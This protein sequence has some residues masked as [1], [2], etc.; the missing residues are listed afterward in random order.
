MS[1]N[2]LGE[3]SAMLRRALD[4]DG[5]DP[6][7]WRIH[8]T[9][10]DLIA[11]TGA[12]PVEAMT[13][14]LIAAIDAPLDEA[15]E[16]VRVALEM[17]T[18]ADRSWMSR[19]D[20]SVVDALVDRAR[21]TGAPPSMVSLAAVLSM[22]HGSLDTV[23]SV[24]S[25]STEAEVRAD[26]AIEAA[27]S[28]AR[29]LDLIDGGRFGE[30]VAYLDTRAGTV[31][32]PAAAAARALALY[33]QGDLHKALEVAAAAPETFETASAQAIVW[34]RRA[35]EGD[36]FDEDV[37]PVAQAS[38][39]ASAAARLEPS[40]ADGLL[41]RAQVE[42]EGL[43][44]VEAGR[45]LLE[46]AVRRLNGE[47]ERVRLWRLQQATRDDDL[48]RYMKVEVAAACNRPGELAAIQP[49]DLP[50]GR[51]AWRQDA[52]VAHLVAVAKENDRDPDGA[53]QMY[54]TA[55]GYY[56]NAGEPDLALDVLRSAT[57]LRPSADDVIQLADDL[58]MASYR[59][60]QQ[61]PEA[62][63]RTI[64]QGLETVDRLGQEGVDVT[65]S[66]QIEGAYR[67]GLLLARVPNLAAV[68]LVDVWRPLPWLLAVALDDPSH[69][70][71]AAHLAWALDRAELAR[72][73]L[74]YAE[75]ALGL[76]DEDAWVQQAYVVM[77]FNWHGVLD[78]RARRFVDAL[79]Y[80]DWGAAMRE[81]DALNRNDDSLLAEFATGPVFDTRWGRAV[82]AQTTAR[83]RGVEEAG[84]LY[85]SLQEEAAKDLID[86]V[87]ASECALVLGDADAA[88]RYVEDAVDAGKLT[89]RSADFRAALIGLV[90]GAN[91]V[92]DT[93]RGVL[94][95]TIEPATLRDWAY[96]LF[97]T[98][99]AAWHDDPD[100][101]QTLE[102]LQKEAEARIANA[103]VLP[104]LTIEIDQRIRSSTE[105]SLDRLVRE[106]LAAEAEGGAAH[107]ET[108]R[109]V[110]S[111]TTVLGNI[112]AVFDA[113]AAPR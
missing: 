13:E 113:I 106:L 30:A 18:R 3:A 45:R 49:E 109:R 104:P 5:D 46:Q 17:L 85:R 70:Y 51:T 91:G 76:V 36:I 66:Q 35:G 39:A 25:R 6:P 16:P 38:R 14:V 47:P 68:S 28:V 43:V 101:V 110:A 112:S 22:L 29:A 105:P 79:G 4:E 20:A 21:E 58:W 40:L 97:P 53:A 88:R 65:S 23:G 9:L 44:D 73:A 63:E 83:L 81:T 42:L 26:P 59:H 56:K 31:E 41:L 50:F 11:R 33:G 78:H 19:L 24:V 1:S 102:G 77:S 89:A 69:A 108:L 90:T 7:V 75:K 10:G 37:D 62:A 64:V 8:L 82:R 94:V 52:A 67:R 57:A 87:T 92:V 99:A 60:E 27:Q 103:S 72:P 80:E 107:W 12:E 48:F 61:G 74:H 32:L 84:P 2:Q 96:S 15:K 71:R 34:L 100:V 95:R 93:I 98:L 54:R 86:P 111:E 55:A